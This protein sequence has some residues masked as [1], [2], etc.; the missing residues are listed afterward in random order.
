MPY[1]K[2]TVPQLITTGVYDSSLLYSAG[3]EKT[4]HRRV[5]MFEIELPLFDGG[6]SYV[7]SEEHPIMSDTLICAKP[8][9]IR[10]TRS[11]FS[12]YYMHVIVKEG[13]LYDT[14]ISLPNFIKTDK[15]EKYLALFKRFCKHYGNGTTS[16]ELIA[17]SVMLEIF[18][19]LVTDAERTTSHEK[20]K[21]NNYAAIESTIAYIK[22][23]L[24]ADLSLEMLAERAGFSAIY[25][26]KC[27]KTSVGMTLREYVEAQRIKRA[28]TLLAQSDMT[29][30]QI[31]YE[32]GFS[33]QSYFSYAFKRSM[34]MTP[35]E[36]ETRLW[37][38][39]EADEQ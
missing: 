24:T 9:Q 19:H 3:T 35:R 18:Y 7:N 15:K 23:N 20:I 38:R 30:T 8:G 6:I 13:E 17:N 25:F 21:N 29:L 22:E 28:T 26:H 1:S 10:H 4:V 2:R 16:E 31:A 39:Y 37:E 27:F 33:S 11:P 14:L 5:S 36:Y 34:G 12:C 32:C